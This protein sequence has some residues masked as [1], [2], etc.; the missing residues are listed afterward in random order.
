MTDAEFSVRVWLIA[1]KH[2]LLSIADDK[3][4]GSGW[5]SD[6]VKVNL[7]YIEVTYVGDL[8]TGLG[9]FSYRHNRWNR[10]EHAFIMSQNTS[11]QL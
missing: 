5:L 8:K 1:V 4:Q 9:S 3:P 7:V 10:G 2:C 11:H 6:Q